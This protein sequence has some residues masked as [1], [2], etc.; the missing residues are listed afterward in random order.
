MALRPNQPRQ[1]SRKSRSVRWGHVH[2]L[3]GRARIGSAIYNGY[4]KRLQQLHSWRRMHKIAGDHMPIRMFGT[5]KKVRP[6]S[7]LPLKVKEQYCVDRG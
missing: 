6:S 1:Y 3:D 4:P 5:R 2:E 7:N